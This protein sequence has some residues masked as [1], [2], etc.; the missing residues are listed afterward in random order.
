MKAAPERLFARDVP[1]RDGIWDASHAGDHAE[2]V[3]TKAAF[4]EKWGSLEQD[5][6][7][8]EGWKQFQYEWY[9]RCYG[10]ANE[11][12][13]AD[14]LRSR[15]VILDAGCGP[16]YKAAWFARLAPDT[17]VVAMDLTDAAVLA[18]KRYGHLPNLIAV[19]GDIATTPFADGV[20]D[21]I[22]CDQVLHHTKSPPDTVE[23]FA[24]I[25]AAAGN[26]NTY[27]YA[28]KALPRELLDEHLRS[29]SQQLSKDEIW[30][31]ADQLTQLGKT[32]S[33]L[34]AEIEVPDMPALGIKGGRQDL[35]RFIYWNFVKCFWNPEHGFEASK[36]IN[37][38]WYSP[39]LA[40]RYSR[41]EFVD[42]LAGAGFRPEFLHSEEACH[43]GRFVK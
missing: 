30:A 26:L 28:K 13:F 33:E 12:E 15:R 9:L 5:P 18:G 29:Y 8:T 25:L 1:F 40:F 35:Q 11:A 22:S 2:E 21:F 3:Q 7:D 6:E 14:F 19:Q 38:D 16:G 39:S 4:S 27:V 20:F 42:M 41:E 31:L 10:Y 34:N 37:F 36:M 23:E 32:L 17:T 24:R 43:T